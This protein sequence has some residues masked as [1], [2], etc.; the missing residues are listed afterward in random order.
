MVEFR[1][2]ILQELI[3]FGGKNELPQTEIPDEIFDRFYESYE[4]AM[5]ETKNLIQNETNSKV[6]KSIELKRGFRPQKRK[7]AEQKNK[8]LD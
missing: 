2:I 5:N 4:Q 8:T 3:K 1:Y 7:Y 6:Q